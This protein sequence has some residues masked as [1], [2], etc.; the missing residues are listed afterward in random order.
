MSYIDEFPS[1]PHNDTLIN[2][3]APRDWQNPTPTER[4][5]LVIIGGGSAGLVAASG[6]AQLGA[7]VAL[8]EKNILGGDCLNVGCVPSKALI[9]AAKTMGTIRKGH[10]HGITVGDVKVDFGKVME[11]VWQSRAAIAPHDSAERFQKMGVD[12]YFGTAKFTDTHCIDVDGVK[13]EFKKALIA[14]GSRP[15]EIPIPGLADTG[16]ITNET[17][18]NLT[19]LPASLAVIGG[20]PIGAEL[21][22]SFQR[23]GTDVTLID[24]APHILP[25]ED[26]DAAEVVQQAL[27]EDGVTLAL[28]AKTELVYADG[29]MKKLDVIVDGEKRTIA[30]EEILLAV[31]R[32]PNVDK[33]N[34][35][36]AGVEYTRRGL[37]VND[38]LQTSNPDIYGAGDVASKYQ[39][40]H[41]AGHSAAIVIQNALFSDFIPLAPKRKISDLIIPWATYTEP[42]I[43]HVGMYAADAE[44]Q[45]IEV[46]TYRAE[47][48]GN[49]RAIA[50]AELDGFVKIHTKKGTDK[51]LGATIVGAG[52]SE[53]LNEITVAM[54][55]DLG[56]GKLM[57]VIH[58]YP[59]KAEAI[60][61]AASEYSKTRLSPT[62]SSITNRWMRFTR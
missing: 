23:L 48:S 11:H 40:T 56:L 16:F 38:Y 42:E 13:L 37:T 41:V 12:V 60:F 46:T 52:A 10:Q 50:D 26:A 19:E 57:S 31:G 20:G 8:V 28:G 34:L 58:P 45:G 5:N 27:I 24:L 29:N 53:M 3:A 30:V 25:R 61:K 47:M 7:K 49:D 59:T 22:Q 18:W 54:K 14:T 51:I 4:Y 43:A 36:V 33:L 6:A 21:A 1:H 44:A 55:Y 32:T 62:V 17:I 9:H 35:E 2:Y 15:L 39:F